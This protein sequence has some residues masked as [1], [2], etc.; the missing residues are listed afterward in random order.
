MV[1]EIRRVC[2][3]CGRKDS[4][5]RLYQ[6]DPIVLLTDEGEEVEFAPDGEFDP[7]YYCESEIGRTRGDDTGCG[8]LYAAEYS[9]TGD[10]A[11]AIVARLLV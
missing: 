3:I 4:A 9:R 6:R 11:E 5:L 1:T 2:L 7:M 8:A 10:E